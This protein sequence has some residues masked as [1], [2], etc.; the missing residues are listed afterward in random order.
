MKIKDLDWEELHT[1]LIFVRTS[2]LDQT[3]KDMKTSP[4]TIARRLSRLEKKLSINLV[5]RRG[6]VSQPETNF[7]KASSS[8]LKLEN[9]IADTFEKMLE[10]VK[11]EELSIRLTTSAALTQELIAPIVAK[12]CKK[13][14]QIQ[15]TVTG[16]SKMLSL[17]ERQADF[18]I[19][20]NKVVDPLL[21]G[22]KIADYGTAL[23]GSKKHWAGKSEKHL[24]SLNFQLV[25]VQNDIDLT[26]LWLKKRFPNKKICARFDLSSSIA[27]CIAH[28]ELLGMLPCILGSSREDLVPI[29]NADN[30]FRM[31]I[32]LLAHRSFKKN[33][34][35]LA[36][37][38]I[39]SEEIEK[40]GPALRG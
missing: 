37:Y 28:S 11:K 40:A 31:P 18:A 1:M 33:P 34:H 20:L 27:N 23:Y 22:K 35:K 8:L 38:H 10:A 24:D 15:L 25:T 26:N 7:S 29:I 2:S 9:V 12:I 3:A 4:T 32:Y 30:A 17:A 21:I 14:P 19:R 36:L 39:L 13:L 6:R 16:E 5:D